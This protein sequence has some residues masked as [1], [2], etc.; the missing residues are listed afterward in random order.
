MAKGINQKLKLLYLVQIFKEQT[1]E[2]HGLTVQEITARLAQND[3]SADRKTLYNDFEELRRFGYDILAEQE[4]RKVT[5][6]LCS[7]LFELPELK[8]LVD[9]VQSS[10]FI[11]ESKSR[12]LIKKLESLV[13]VHQAKELH[14]Q[15]ILSGRIKTMN[16]SIYYSV[17]RIHAAINEDRQISFQYFQ[18]NVKKEMV[19]RRGGALYQVSPWALLW[20]DENYYLIAYDHDADKIK[21][22]RVDKMRTIELLDLPRSGHDLFQATNVPAYAKSLFGMFSGEPTHVTLECSTDL[23]GAIIDRFGK[24][25]PLI[26]LGSEH[27]EAHVRVTA[28][29]PFLAWVFSLGDG[30]RITAPASLVEAMREEAR[31]LFDR[32]E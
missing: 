17:D 10:K 21:H 32:Y 29:R 4:G 26:P 6:R 8:L 14:R 13:S 20:D 12:E 19:L 18:W 7:R 15:V 28:S 24:D 11:T 22:Y 30:I 9:T 2:D 23:V 31:R 3:V 16:E 1:D 25:I 27:F 5:Y